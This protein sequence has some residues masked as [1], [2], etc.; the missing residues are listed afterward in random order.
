MTT[1]KKTPYGNIFFATTIYNNGR[2]ENAVRHTRTLFSITT[3]APTRQYGSDTQD[4]SPAAINS[5]R[6]DDRARS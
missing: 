2:R 4:V 3:H 1:K 5:R 6:S